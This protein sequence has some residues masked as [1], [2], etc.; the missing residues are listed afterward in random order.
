MILVTLFALLALAL[1][2]LGIYGLIARLVQTQ[3]KEIGIRVT[4]GAPRGRIVELVLGGALRPVLI[5]GLVG[6][7]GAVALSRL[8]ESLLYEVNALDPA[9]FLLTP[10]LLM[11]TALLAAWLPARRATAI[12]PIEA[13]RQS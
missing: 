7:A 10:L 9:T 4:L 1:A 12:D 5:G 2:G 13:L 8:L 6:I 3:V 11:A